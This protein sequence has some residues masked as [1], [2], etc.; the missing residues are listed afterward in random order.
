MKTCLI[1][2]LADRIITALEILLRHHDTQFIQI[3]KNS[4]SRCLFKFPVNIV[5]IALKNVADGISGDIF[6]IMILKIIQN[7]VNCC[8]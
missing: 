7:P 6:H 1:R 2:N 8:G 4:F 5:K 3:I